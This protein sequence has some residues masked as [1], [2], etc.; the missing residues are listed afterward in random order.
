MAACLARE[1]RLMLIRLF[2]F[3]CLYRRRGVH[4]SLWG[5]SLNRFLRHS[6]IRIGIYLIAYTARRVFPLG[7]P[8]DFLRSSGR[9]VVLFVKA[10][11]SGETLI[12]DV[13]KIMSGA[14]APPGV[15]GRLL[16]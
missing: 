14:Y 8:H 6:F 12:I 15:A 7:A 3:G 11:F 4:G 13:S 1:K 10:F 16:L 9:K 2:Y 5:A